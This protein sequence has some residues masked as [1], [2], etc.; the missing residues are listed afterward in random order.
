MFKTKAVRFCSATSTRRPFFSDRAG[1]TAILFGLTLVP[2]MLAVG[3][4]AD[5]GRAA[6]LRS[7]LQAAADAAVLSA[8]SRTKLTQSD[9]AAIAQRVVA[10]NMVGK[11]AGASINVTEVEPANGVFQVKVNATLDTA[12]MKIAHV[13]TMSVSVSSEARNVGGSVNPIEIA[14]AL[15]NTGSMRNDMAALKSAAKSLVQSVMSNDANSKTR[16]SVVPYVATVNPGLPASALLDTTAT[17]PFTGNWFNYGWLAY[18]AT[19]TPVW[20]S[21]GT[22]SNPGGSSSGDSSG[23]ASDLINI[24]SPFRRIARELFGVSAAFAADVTPNTI[25]ALALQTLTN[26]GKSYSAPIGFNLEPSSATNGGC[27][28]LLNPGRINP[29]ELFARLKG[30][31]G[32]AV[33]W[34]GC[35]EARATSQEIAMVNGSWGGSY[36]TGVDYD[37][38]D[39]PP[40]AG[41][42][43]SL[44]T[45]YFWPDEPDMSSTTWGPIAPGPFV[46]GSGG[47]HNNYLADFTFPNAWGWKRNDWNDGQ[48]ILKYDGTTHAAVV[49]ETAPSTYGPN[50]A[51]PEPVTR[52]TNNQSQVLTA[53]DR[54]SYWNNGG[55]VISEGFTW[56]WRTLS[57]QLPYADGQAYDD[58]KSK[59]VIVLMTDGVNGIA[60]NGNSASNHIS[61]YS[62]YGYLG[63]SRLHWADGVASYSDLQ[64]FLD[65]RLKM[66]CNNAKAKGIKIY[67]VMFNHAGFLNAAEQEHSASLLQ[68]C[69]SQPE[70][71]YLAT[72][73]T[74]LQAAFDQI[75]ASAAG[76]PLRLSR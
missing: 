76:S 60:D 45:A 32:Q 42:H 31:N 4:A 51:C 30:P 67:T 73:Q 68:Y 14:L 34:K 37:V 12:V 6:R 44:F 75:A 43:A 22:T 17:A 56:A 64:T 9:R 10:A 55:T 59:K 74:A 69:A 1:T 66:A 21:G 27:N 19:C 8:G 50:A 38:T 29:Y 20:G 65:N 63:A 26:G 16:V 53:I 61:D 28:W 24:I 48:D 2:V 39:T 71:A 33:A 41:D 25:P 35:V 23:D 40:S 36:N 52:L 13:D 62:A 47:F 57:P 70:Y 54:M 3:V 7:S 46:A 15:D 18:D 58:P 11:V 49:S 5:Y 72:N